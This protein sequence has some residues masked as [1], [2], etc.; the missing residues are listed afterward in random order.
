MPSNTTIVRKKDAAPGPAKYDANRRKDV[1]TPDRVASKENRAVTP[2]GLDGPFPVLAVTCAAPLPGT[3]TAKPVGL[4]VL[5]S[6]LGRSEVAA[7][8][9]DG[10]VGGDNLVISEEVGDLL[11]RHRNH[12]PALEAGADERWRRTRRPRIPAV[13]KPRYPKTLSGLDAIG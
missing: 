9:D 7:R 10:P 5:A 12:F 1:P 8:S 4:S 11:Q 3:A 13:A 2:N 6:A